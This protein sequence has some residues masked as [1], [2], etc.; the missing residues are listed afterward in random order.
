MVRPVDNQLL[1]GNV[2]YVCLTFMVIKGLEA[3][4][5]FPLFKNINMICRFIVY[6]LKNYAMVL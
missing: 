4:P 1:I 2:S 3:I 5:F 6:D